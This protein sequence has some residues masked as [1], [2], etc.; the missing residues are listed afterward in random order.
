[1]KDT[2]S[3]PT[4][5]EADLYRRLSGSF[6]TGVCVVT[7]RE[8][9]GTPR[10]LTTQ[11]FVGLSADPA[12]MLVSVDRSSRTLE[13]LK[14]SGAFVINFLEAGHDRLALRFASKADDKFTDVRW[15]PS[16]RADGAPVL[17]EGIVAYAECR[18]VQSIEAGDHWIVIGSLVG[19][20]VRGGQPL[21]YYRRSY[22]AWPG[23]A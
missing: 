19:G 16:A 7:T 14:K 18:T 9:D 13:A 22:A 6:P 3:F 23:Q 15:S 11:S 12:L 4:P 21:L 1:V 20:E 5:P 8:P 17:D 2:Q 10:G